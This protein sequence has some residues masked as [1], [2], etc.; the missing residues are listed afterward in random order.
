MLPTSTKRPA[1]YRK[2]HVSLP[3][4]VYERVEAKSSLAGAPFSTTLS[5]LVRRALE[6]EDQARLDEALRLDAEANVA[7]ARAVGIVTAR[8]WSATSEPEER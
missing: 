2:V 8:V 5:E 6:R 1:P 4:D 7:F 3:A